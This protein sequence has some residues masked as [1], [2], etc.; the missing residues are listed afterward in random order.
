M[1]AVK[2][3][4]LNFKYG[5]APVLTNVS[6]EIQEGEYVGI[7]G[8]NGG[9][10]STLLKLLMGFLEPESGSIKI[11]GEN[12]DEARSQ[13]AYVPQTLSC[14]KQFPISVWEV[15]LSGRI[16]HINWWGLY[17]AKDK[18]IALESL[19]EVGMENF[20]KV[21]FGTLSG[22]QMQ[23]V[24]IARALASCPKLLLFDEPTASVDPHAEAEI[25]RLLKQLKKD[26]TILIVTH[27]L[28]AAI[29]Q[30]ERLLL[31]QGTVQSMTLAEVCEHFAMGLYHTPIVKAD[32]VIR[33]GRPQ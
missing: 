26:M 10:K 32:H 12:P 16:S 33:F 29:D 5:A 13:I 4:R 18:K 21:P 25:Y 7:M 3:D 22:G 14:D 19:E 31:V 15:V 9:G 6:F 20:S 1:T 28:N 24:L 30:V 17:S 8:P 2:V 11:F 23:R 27:D